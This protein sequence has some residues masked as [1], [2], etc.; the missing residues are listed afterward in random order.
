MI[1]DGP[2]PILP[3]AFKSHADP[4]RALTQAYTEKFEQCVRA[5][6]DQWFWVHDRWKTAERKPEPVPA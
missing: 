6:P 1:T 4:V 5:H 3:E 2:D